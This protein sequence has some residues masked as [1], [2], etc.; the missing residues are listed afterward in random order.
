ML[1]TITEDQARS[2]AGDLLTGDVKHKASRFNEAM[3]GLMGNE[4]IM[5]KGEMIWLI[6]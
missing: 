4:F 6:E 3:N 1:K 2:V 5:R